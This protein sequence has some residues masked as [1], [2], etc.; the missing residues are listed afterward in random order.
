[1]PFVV[2]LPPASRVMSPL[3]EMRFP[4]AVIFF[5]ASISTSL[6]A[7]TLPVFTL[8][9]LELSVALPFSAVT[10]PLVSISP[11]ALAITLLSAFTV[12]FVVMLP[13]RASKVMSPLLE[14]RFPPAVI[15]I[16]A[17]I[18]TSFL[19]VTLPVFT[20]PVLE[21]SFALPVCAVTSPLVSISPLALAITLLSAFTVPFVVML[22]P[23]CK[24]TL[25]FVE[26]RSPLAVILFAALI[27]TSLLAITF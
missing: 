22:P 23:A 10:S 3:L 2:I 14:M 5:A 6:L 13:L 11:L 8:P 17:S 19:A 25:A 18:S 20:L 21:L 4:P 16:A 24:S 7:V 27:S 12:P 1:M 26:V 15:S 9:V